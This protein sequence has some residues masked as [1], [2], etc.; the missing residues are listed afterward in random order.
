MSIHEY[1]TEM[2]LGERLIFVTVYIEFDFFPG[3]PMV[4]YYSDGSGHPG[5]D[6]EIEPTLVIVTTAEIAGDVLDRKAL[7]KM[8]GDGS[9]L[10]YLDRLVANEVIKDCE[11]W[12]PLCEDM[13]SLTGEDR[14]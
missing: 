5:S 9:W 8:G 14:Y 4:R 6:P 3:E 7:E 11:N 10:D 13:V 12:G 1:E 2:E